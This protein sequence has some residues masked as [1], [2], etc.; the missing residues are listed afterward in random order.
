M[1]VVAIQTDRININIFVNLCN[2]KCIFKGYYSFG[3]VSVFSCFT[4]FLV[5]L[6]FILIFLFLFVLFNKSNSEM[7]MIKLLLV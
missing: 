1:Y 2:K 3:A 6:V 4:E 5:S 7:R